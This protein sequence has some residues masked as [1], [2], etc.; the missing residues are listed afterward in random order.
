[1]RPR[2]VLYRLGFWAWSEIIAGVRFAVSCALT[3][4]VLLLLF[5]L[6][7]EVFVL[8]RD[9]AWRSVSIRKLLELGDVRTSFDVLASLPAELVLP[10]A[11][12]VLFA[13]RRW[14]RALERRRAGSERENVLNDMERAFHAR[15]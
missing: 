4:T 8:Q 11:A 15:W 9:G 1:M 14:L 2:G 13:V 3:V 12:L 6:A 5:V 7:S 10:V